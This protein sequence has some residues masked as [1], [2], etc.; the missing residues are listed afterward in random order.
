MTSHESSLLEM[1]KNSENI[2]L[3]L[4]Q[5]SSEINGI[6]LAC[7]ISFAIALTSESLES[8]SLTTKLSMNYKGLILVAK[9]RASLKR[10]I[11]LL[12]NPT[13]ETHTLI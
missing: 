13:Q 7:N 11:Q 8:I 1:K 4:W 2:T 10:R 6:F 9:L 5:T 12:L 3:N